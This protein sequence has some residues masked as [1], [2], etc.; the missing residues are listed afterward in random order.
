MIDLVALQSLLALDAR[1]TVAAAAAS[2]GYTPSAVS[3]QIKRLEQQAGVP[4]TERVGRRVVLTEQ[5]RLLVAE[6]REVLAR[7]EQLE[8][9]LLA[10]G[11][12]LAG[13]LRLAA[14]STGVRGLVAPL[15]GE[16]R[17]TA[18]ALELTV[19]EED[20]HQAVD[21]VASGQ[22]DLA[23][24][25]SW[26]GVGLS[27]PARVRTEHL[28]DDEADLLVHRDHPLAG[29]ESVTPADLLDEVWASTQPGT[30]CYEWFTV[31]FAA[32][33]LPRVRFWS[34]EFE[35]QVRLVQEGLA[36]ALVPRLGR[37]P[38]PAEVV[39]VPVRAP[40]PTRTVRLLWR[41]TMDASPTV[42]HVREVLR[43]VVAR[44]AALAPP[45]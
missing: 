8:S 23:L 6:G 2:L 43:T 38:L 40:V 21:L 25:H 20:P 37:S 29:R 41:E 17:R 45:A 24:V 14:F 27:V 35:S 39:A 7:V 32:L 12:E 16:L 5:A 33:R 26:V 22:V 28:G 44:D 4:L 31:M 42:R 9:A 1:G 15:A 18:P 30:I 36:V 10:H 3:Q 11:D 19:A 13:S 34:F